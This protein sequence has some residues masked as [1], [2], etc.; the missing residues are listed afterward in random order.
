M[1]M[2]AFIIQTNRL[3]FGFKPDIKVVEN[4]NLNIPAAQIYGFLGPNGAGKTTT[5]RLILGLLNH[6]SEPIKIFG[7][8]LKKDRMEIYSRIGCLIEQ[9][10]LYEHL[11]AADNLHIAAIMRNVPKSRINESLRSVK[12][13]DNVN[14]KVK[15]FSLGMKQRLGL[16]IALLA[17]PELLILDEPTNGLDPLGIVEIR[18]ILINLNQKYGKTIF[19]SSHMLNEVDKMCSIMGIINKGKLLFEGTKDELK[20]FQN[21]N[22]YVNFCVNDTEKA[23]ELLSNQLVERFNGSEIRVPFQSKEKV[24]EMTR[25]FVNNRIDIYSIKT[26]NDDLEESFLQLIGK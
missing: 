17:D 7:K 4:L 21:K 15:E 9:P 2:P 16:A 26:T 20:N 13:L 1:G 25:L 19:L 24:A 18:E 22:C 11:T 3:T 23:A 14:R 8:D 12:L 5:I 6:N 10:S